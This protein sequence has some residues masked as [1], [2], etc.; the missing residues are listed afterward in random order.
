MSQP[1]YLTQKI[2]LDPAL[3]G[4]IKGV[5]Y[6]GAAIPQW[7]PYSNLVVDLSSLKV[8][9]AKTPMLRDHNPSQV[10]GHSKVTLSGNQ[11]DIDGQLSLKTAHGQEITL[12]AEDGVEWELSLGVFE[13]RMEEV[14]DTEVNGVMYP[15][16]N[17]LRDGLLR[18]V[19]VVIIGADVNTN[20]TVLSHNQGDNKIMKQLTPEQYVALACACGGS[21]DSSPEELTE[22]AKAAKLDA[23][24]DKAKVEE[25][26]SQI[27]ALKSEI[28]AKQAELDKIKGAEDEAK[29]EGDIQSA[30]N[31][32]N[33]KLSAEKIKDAAKTKEKTDV[34][35]SVIADMEAQ[36]AIDPN[37]GKKLD[38]GG[39]GGG[40]AGGDVKLKADD[41]EG[42][43]LAARKLVEEGKAKDLMSALTMVKV[44]EEK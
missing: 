6:S 1:V 43:R 13:G 21:K 44:E 14:R 18:E 37:M 4:V 33:I 11:L 34:L 3:K 35:L 9:K 29:R 7:G 28:A 20:A 19:S 27:E 39:K 40:A 41:H 32:K 8:A 12:L 31:A 42:I 26:N 38:L 5:A 25:L 24:S 30:A 17:V 16:A 36:K 23:E 2:N 15:F 22:K 10:A